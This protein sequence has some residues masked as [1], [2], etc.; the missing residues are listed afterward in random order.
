MKQNFLLCCL[1]LVLLPGCFVQRTTVQQY[2]PV[3]KEEAPPKE[4]FEGPAELTKREELLGLYGARLNARI[5]AY[6]KWAS[7]QNTKN[8]YVV[9]DMDEPNHKDKKK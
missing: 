7:E 9:I 8:G 3:I 5:K 4:A 2:K 6:N 1:C